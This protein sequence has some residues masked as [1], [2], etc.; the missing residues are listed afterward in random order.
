MKTRTIFRLLVCIGQLVVVGLNHSWGQLPSHQ[1]SGRFSHLSA[2]HGLSQNSVLCIWQDRDGFLWLGTRD[3]LNKYDGYSF[4][5]YKPD[6]A[7]PAHTFGHNVITSICEDRAGRMWVTTLGG[8]LHRF[9]RRSGKAQAFRIDPARISLR[10][11]MY[12]VIEDHEGLLW[13]ASREGLNRFDPKTNTF[14]TFNPPSPAGSDIYAVQEDRGGKLWVGTREGLFRFDR[15]TTAY[16]RIELPLE[17]ADT[18]TS[19]STLV[20]DPAGTLWIQSESG[21]LYQMKPGNAP[22][23]YN[24]FKTVRHDNRSLSL[25]GALFTDRSGNVWIA[26][27]GQGGLFRLELATGQWVRFHANQLQSGSLS[28]NMI[29]SIFQDR[30]GSIWVGTDNGLDK[31][32]PVPEK[33]QTFQVVLNNGAT[34]LPENSIRALCQDH[35][36]TIWLSN[37]SDGL[38]SYELRT[39]VYRY[40]PADAAQPGQLASKDVNAIWE[41]HTG[42]LWIGAGSYLHRYDR[43]TGRFTRFFSEVGVRSI[44]EGSDGTLWIG[45]RGMARFDPRTQQFVYYRHDPKNPASLSDEG[46]IVALPTRDGTVW[47]ASSRKGLSRLTVATGRF[48]HYQPD[49]QYSQGHVNDK[50]IR[51]LYEDS[52]GRL[53]IGTNQGGLN[54][55][56]S[57]TDSFTAF[58][59]HNGLPSNHIVGILEDNEGNL[60]LA[61]NH[62]VCRFNPN[63]YVC[64]NYD[65]SDG[66]QANEFFEAYARGPEGDL[67]FGGANGFSLFSPHTIRTNSRIPP[68][69]ITSVQIGKKNTA[70]PE[71]PLTLLYKDNDLS[72]DF[73]A[74]NFIQ[75]EKNQYAYQLVGVDKDW[76]YCGTRRFVSYPNLPPGDYQFRVKAA[77]NDGVWNEKG[78]LLNITIQPPFW[79]TGWFIILNA[80]ALLGL[81]YGGF[82]FRIRQ[83]ERKER[84]KTAINKKLAEMEMQA[85][86]AQM[87]PHFIFNSLNSINR[88]IMKNESEAASDYL[89]KFSKLIRLILQHAT[90]PTVSLESELEALSLYVKLES[91]RFDGQFTFAIQVD[92]QIEPAYTIIPPMII[93]PYVENAIWHGLMQKELGGHLTID[94]RKQNELL[95]CTIEDNGV[96][97]Q[98]AAELRSKSATHAKSMGMQ[99]TADRLKLSQTLYGQQPTVV[100]HDLVDALGEPAGTRVVLKIPL[101]QSS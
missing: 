49:F 39:G 45:G 54:R 8:G 83:I 35:T 80:I 77:N 23:S 91:V 73:V 31:L 93:Q 32:S 28:S 69:H 53:W 25:S 47:A 36:G 75:S 61:T 2:E 64:R 81:I 16:T 70:L 43:K 20:A 13:I 56:D 101:A 29:Y 41:D 96:G 99:I 58:T 65:K 78:A 5:V 68:V 27:P 63:S 66:L 92:E 12:S 57:K 76:V 74:L 59:T 79:R 94:V 84:Q 34:R 15:R 44:R 10:N 14:Q 67:L 97:R 72:F 33:F 52:R 71:K 19:I 82:R 100:I 51:C 11:V 50:D 42:Q 88:F 60:W 98:K 26:P 7:D 38:Y 6:P 85:L 87:N 22:V 95:I 55:Y 86:R 4:T 37:E 89:S 40:F 1:G 30:E 21:K 17:A 18:T 46:L 24:T 90:A 48:R 3:G 9:D 62:G